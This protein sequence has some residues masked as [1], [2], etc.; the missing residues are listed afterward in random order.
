MGRSSWSVGVKGVKGAE[1]VSGC[2]GEAERV[3]GGE[4]VD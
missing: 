1:Q 3:G 4:A 2:K